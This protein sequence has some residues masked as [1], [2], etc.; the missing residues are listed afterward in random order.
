MGCGMVV[1]EN[2]HQLTIQV[3]GI[4]GQ[5]N[6]IHSFGEF[7]LDCGQP[8]NYLFRNTARPW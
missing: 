3:H 7:R 2:G 8:G 4:G 1:I 6:A 5:D